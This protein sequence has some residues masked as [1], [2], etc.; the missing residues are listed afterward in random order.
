VFACYQVSIGD[1]FEFL[2]NAWADNANFPAN[3]DGP[4]PV[5]GPP[6]SATT[7]AAATNPVNFGR[8]ISVEGAL[9]CFTPSIPTLTAL[10]NGTALLET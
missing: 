1:Q 9:Y 2:Q 10:A 5:V 8:F 3:N 4:D 7:P 6:G